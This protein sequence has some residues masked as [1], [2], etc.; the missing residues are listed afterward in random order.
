MTCA[1]H[2]DFAAG[3]PWLFWPPHGLLRRCLVAL[4]ELPEDEAFAIVDRVIKMNNRA[5]IR[6]VSLSAG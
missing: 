4:C 1:G 3:H 5:E 6:D 2:N